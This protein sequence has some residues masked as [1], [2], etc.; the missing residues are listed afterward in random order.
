KLPVIFIIENNGY[1]LSTP[2]NEQYNCKDLVDKAIG[3]G[4]EGIQIDGNNITE[5]YDTI[6]EC[7]KKIIKDPRPIL[8]ECKTFR[9]RGHE[10]ASG[11]KYV[12]KEL[13]EEWKQKDPINR[14]E[15]FLKA[16]NILSTTDME[17]IQKEK[18]AEIEAALKVAFDEPQIEASTENELND[19]YAPFDFKLKESRSGERKQMRFVDAISNAL[20]VGLKAFPELVIMGQDIAEYGGVFKIT[21]NFIED[22]GKERIKNTPICESAIVGAGLGLSI[23]DHKAIIEMQ[24][25]DFVTCGFNQIINNLAKLHYRWQEKA[26]VV[27]RMPC[28]AGVTAGPFHSQSNEAWFA[29][30]PGLKVVYPSNPYD[31][32]GLLLASIEDPNPVI[33]FEHKALYRS[34][35]DE[36]PVDYYNVEIGKA[37]LVLEGQDISIIT[38]GM[39]VHWA[40]KAVEAFPDNSIEILDLRSLLPF[41]KEAIY[42]TTKKTGKVLILHEDC[43][44]GG[45]GGELS[46][47]ISENCFEYLDAPLVRCG[48]MDSPVPFIKQLEDQFLASSKLNDK[49]KYLIEY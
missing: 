41:D 22:F 34:I 31:A 46:A 47:F 30:T 7:K 40:K 26:D 15:D 43:L 18:V 33:F 4:M 13:I 17:R 44:T 38:Y 45:I 5:V 37:R 21:E 35:R 20:H 25:A 36:V 49:L 42:E 16:E 3:Y 2:T 6:K 12:P 32:K 39:G 28:G 27:V 9:I 11:V 1:G 24:F 29:H 10:E 48:S 8:I 14:F 19:V 23:N